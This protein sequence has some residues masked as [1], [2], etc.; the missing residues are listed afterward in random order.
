MNEERS[1][2]PSELEVGNIFDDSELIIFKGAEEMDT[3]V[4]E[5]GMGDHARP[6]DLMVFKYDLIPKD[7]ELVPRLNGSLEV[8]LDDETYLEYS[9]KLKRAGL[10]SDN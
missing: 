9:N 10:L 7:G 3:I 1:F 2:K 5:S 6:Y 4:H 8:H